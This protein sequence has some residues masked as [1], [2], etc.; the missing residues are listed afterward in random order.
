[1]LLFQVEIPKRAAACHKGGETLEPGQEYFSLLAEGEVQG[2]Y[3]RN[4]FCRACWDAMGNTPQTI[5]GAGS[6][7]STVPQG[8]MASDLPKKKDDRA[9]FLLKEA[10]NHQTPENI[11]EAFVLSLYLARRR[12][13][14]MR[15]EMI[16]PQRGAFSIYEVLETEEMLCVPKLSLSELQVEK[17]QLELA[18]KFKGTTSA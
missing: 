3:L 10:L 12:L 17:L 11:P 8:K 4:D 15:H 16:Q 9:L 5:H 18:K 7:R 14:A 13:L 2:T 6:W 1:M